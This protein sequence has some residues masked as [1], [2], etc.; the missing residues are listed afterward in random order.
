MSD[1][2]PP[3]SAK[4]V[5][6]EDGRVWLRKNEW[7]KWELPGGRMDLDEQPEQ[8]V[9][10]ELREE[11]GLEVSVKQL[12]DAY[13]WH[14]DFGRHPY[15]LLITYLCKLEKRVGDVEHIGEGGLAEFKT[16]KP[17]DLD[18]IDLPDPYR[19]AIKL[20]MDQ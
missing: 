5:V 15:I 18:A 2:L 16:Y 7:G 11:L 17:H 19:R 14:K 4:G 1:F 3:V 6:L 9:V 10:R 13:I 12:V 8:T 20:A